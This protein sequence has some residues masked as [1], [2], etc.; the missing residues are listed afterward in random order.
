[1]PYTFIFVKYGGNPMSS[2]KNIKDMNFVDHLSELRNRLIVTAVFFILAFILSLVFV[3][4]IY[5]FFQNDIDFQ[6]TVT[7]ITDVIWV[8]IAIAAL[9][10][11]IFTLPLLSLQIWLF[12]RPGLT[13]K[14]RR[15]S[16]AYIPAILILF[17]AGLVA[18]YYL[19]ANIILPFLLRWNDGTFNE[20][21]TVDKYFRTLMNFTLPFGFIFEVPIILMFLTSLGILTPDFLRKNRKYAYFILLIIGGLV[22]PPD[23]ILQISVAIPLFL[24]YELS[25]YL[26]NVVYKRRE[27]RHKEYMEG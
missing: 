3:K 8:Y 5:N 18:G 20:M 4:D 13:K 14:E 16:L 11:L 7:G 6:L 12:I 1:M 24:L 9:I 26:T 23:V 15:V 27:K 25:I 2:D 19:F 10:A 22:T 21:F 17:V